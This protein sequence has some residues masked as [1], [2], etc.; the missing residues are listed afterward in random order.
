MIPRMGSGATR[1]QNPFSPFAPGNIFERDM[2]GAARAASQKAATSLWRQMNYD[3]FSF[4]GGLPGYITGKSFPKTNM[5]YST[6]AIYCVPTWTSTQKVTL[7]N[8]ETGKPFSPS[9]L[10]GYCE[11]VPMPNVTKVP[12]GNILAGGTDKEMVVIRSNATGTVEMWE[13][14]QVEGTPG[15]YTAHYGG[16]ISD[17]RTF[18]GVLPNNWGARATSLACM[19]G[20]ITLQDLVEI[21]LGRTDIGHAIEI[22]IPVTGPSHVAPATRSDKGGGYDNQLPAE[23]EGKP[24]PAASNEDAIDEGTWFVFPAAAHPS[25]YGIT[26][27]LEVALFNT[28][29][30]YGYFIG[31]NAGVSA[32]SLNV[33]C[34]IAL[35]SPYSWA[36][37]DPVS[38]TPMATERGSTGSGGPNEEVTYVPSSWRDPSLTAIIEHLAISPHIHNTQ[39]C[40]TN[41]PWD[42]GE[43]LEPFSP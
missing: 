36:R 3:N 1:K 42:I 28:F 15:A 17:L 12:A 23:Y 8:P 32:C 10:Q 31:D 22:A 4:S 13:F 39:C 9:G 5:T 37:V 14:W 18:A 24:N 30:K 25:E 6:P 41:Q 43:V 40:L 33:E 38:G 35:G 11:A 7:I 27:P 16:Y 26:Q 19:G 29:Q 2:Q 34:P 21:S 20:T